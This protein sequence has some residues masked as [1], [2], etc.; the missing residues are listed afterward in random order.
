[1]KKITR[2]IQLTEIE[3]WLEEYS[4]N[5]VRLSLVGNLNEEQIQR[6]LKKRGL[7]SVKWELKGVKVKF[8]SMDIQK[9]IESA[10][11]KGE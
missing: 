6:A 3:Y 9:F 2:K 10:D 8:F 5:K 7:G 11:C 1:M 4:E